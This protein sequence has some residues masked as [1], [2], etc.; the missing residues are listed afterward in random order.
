MTYGLITAGRLPLREDFPA[1]LTGMAMTL[2]GQESSPPLTLL[3]LERRREDL[4]GLVDDTIPVTFTSKARLSGFY[5]VQSAK[6][7]LVNW[8]DH[9]VVTLDWTLE[10]VRLGTEFELDHESRLSGPLTRN[11]SHAVTGERWLAPPVGHYGFWA[12]TSTPP[13]VTRTGVDG[14]MLVYRDVPAT[15]PRWGTTPGGMLA[16][17][18]RFLDSDAT[19]RTGTNFTPAATGWELANGLVRVR[20][21]T[22]GG[23]L[24]VAAWDPGAGSWETKTWDVT[25]GGVSLGAPRSVTLLRNQLEA[26]VVRVLWGTSA[27]PG[28]TTVDLTLRRGSRFVELY[29]QNATST[30][31]AI[32]RAAAEVATAGTGYV[33]A[34]ADDAAGN[35]YVLGSAQ[36]FTTD[37]VAGGISKAATL[38]LDAFVGVALAGGAAVAGDQPDQ[39]MAQYLGSPGEFVVPVRR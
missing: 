25:A 32:V 12:G 33:R 30:T 34:T 6:A 39:L 35:R 38:T 27:G 7:D 20:P 23:V 16:G 5:R 36:A 29:V 10:L 31:L 19:E 9:A 18:V 4:L 11:T 22:A 2:K 21:L 1:G 14:A 15:H 26:V 3:E 8:A 28:R 37:L 17:R 13:A 24:E